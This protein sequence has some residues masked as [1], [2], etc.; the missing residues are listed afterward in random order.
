MVFVIMLCCGFEVFP[1][2]SLV[3]IGAAWEV[4]TEKHFGVHKNAD[5]FLLTWSGS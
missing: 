3:G 5:L 2:L 1:G 4:G